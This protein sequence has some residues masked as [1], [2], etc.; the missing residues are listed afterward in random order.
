MRAAHS[1]T[2]VMPWTALSMDHA[3]EHFNEDC[4]GGGGIDSMVHV[5]DRLMAWCLALHHR[6]A[7]QTAHNA[8]FSRRSASSCD[9]CGL[10]EDANPHAK[11][12]VRH[13]DV[14]PWNRRAHFSCVGQ[15]TASLRAYGLDTATQLTLDNIV[16]DTISDAYTTAEVPRAREL[17]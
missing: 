7:M 8:T 11:A 12:V 2:A 13:S 4:K 17:K 6:L 16:Y 1:T 15:L 9:A 5:W 14:L 10:D 3:L